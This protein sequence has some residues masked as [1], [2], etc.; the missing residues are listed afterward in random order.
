[1]GFEKKVSG[2]LL[3]VGTP[4]GNLGDLS[5]RAVETLKTADLIAAEDTRHAALLLKKYGIITRSVS[6]HQHSDPQKI[7]TLL[8]EGKKIALISD[9]GTPG[10]SDPGTRLVAEAIAAGYAV[11]PVPGP[12]AIIAALCASGLPTDRFGFFGFVPHKKGRETFFRS[13][14]ALEHTA[15]FYESTH[16]IQK[17]VEQLQQWIPDRRI[18]LARELTKIHEEFLRG[19]PAEILA[20]FQKTPEKMK[21]EF[22]VLVAGKDYVAGK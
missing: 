20:V 2:C 17:C 12:S 14:A 1:M 21:G 18:V 5:L 16:R 15:I 8:A 11:S 7:L 6:Y 9:A 3:I 13:L 22:V 4:I 10:I 19:H